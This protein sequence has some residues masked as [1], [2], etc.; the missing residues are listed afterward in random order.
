MRNIENRHRRV[1]GLNFDASPLE[2]FPARKRSHG[3][4]AYAASGGRIMSVANLFPL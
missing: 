2:I 4:R 1:L 3:K